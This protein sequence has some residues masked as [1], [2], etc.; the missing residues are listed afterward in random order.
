M[1]KN[2]ASLALTDLIDRFNWLSDMNFGRR[3]FVD[4]KIISYSA[5]DDTRMLIAY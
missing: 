2:Y 5:E 4:H 1:I 3:L